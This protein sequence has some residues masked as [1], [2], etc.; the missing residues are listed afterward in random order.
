MR[1]VSITT[2]GGR[3]IANPV[4]VASSFA[5]RLV[6]LLNRT[7]L[8]AGSGLL[9]HP[10]GS[11]HTLGMRFVIDVLYLDRHMTVLACRE[12][13]APH[14]LS[15]APRGTH[16]VLELAAGEIERCAVVTGERLV[17]SEVIP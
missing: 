10:G 2:A 11:T 15:L 9:L 17:L 5:A 8:A 1:V 16:Y 13:L 4:E 7:A 14:R 3:T 6:G 12:R